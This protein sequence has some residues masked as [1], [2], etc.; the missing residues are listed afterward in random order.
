VDQG[1]LQRVQSWWPSPDGTRA[2]IG[3]TRE[4]HTGVEGRIALLRL[5]GATGAPV[6]FGPRVNPQATRVGW[7]PDSSGF[8]VFARREDGTL[9]CTVFT[10]DL[11]E[12][13]SFAVPGASGP[14][15]GRSLPIPATLEEQLAALSNGAKWVAFAAGGGLH[16]YDVEQS[17]YLEVPEHLRAGAVVSVVGW[18]RDGRLA[19]TCT[20][21]DPDDRE[22]VLLSVPEWTETRTTVSRRL[23]GIVAIHPDGDP[24]LAVKRDDYWCTWNLVWASG[25]SDTLRGPGSTDRFRGW[26]WVPARG[27]QRQEPDAASPHLTSR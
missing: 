15:E 21:K 10:C 1:V 22:L 26:G 16:V 14:A 25:N 18:L 12:V 6:L 5:D 8:A 20:A 2:V 7:A 23:G 4:E 9:G 19:L 24:Y 17:A 3:G 13:A 11:G 27:V